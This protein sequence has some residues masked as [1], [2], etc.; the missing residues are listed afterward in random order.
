MNISMLPKCEARILFEK[1]QNAVVALYRGQRSSRFVKGEVQ[2]GWFMWASP[3]YTFQ[4]FNDV[5]QGL[6]TR[7]CLK[8]TT[9]STQSIFLKGSWIHRVFNWRTCFLRWFLWRTSLTSLVFHAE[10]PQQR[11]SASWFLAG[12]SGWNPWTWCQL[13]QLIIVSLHLTYV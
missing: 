2:E 6:L 13:K 1:S 8:T 11:P 7:K 4:Q 10:M 3:T 5:F 9:C 12:P